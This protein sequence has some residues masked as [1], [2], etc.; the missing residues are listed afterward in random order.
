MNEVRAMPAAMML[1]GLCIT[2]ARAEETC[3]GTYGFD[4]E[5]YTLGKVKANVKRSYFQGD[6]GVPSK[7][8]VV[9]GDAVMVTNRKPDAVCAVYVSRKGD[10]TSGWLNLVDIDMLAVP[11]MKPRAW[12]GKWT[13]G[14]RANLEISAA[15]K[16][17]LSV[18]GEALWGGS[19]ADIENGNVNTGGVDGDAPVENGVLSFAV[20]MDGT[21]KTFAEAG[22]YE[23]AIRLRPLGSSYLLAED[24]KN[25]GGHNVSFTGL[26]A[27][28]N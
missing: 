10:E 4:E 18:S 17:W 28:A 13:A 14:E 26:Y 23:C 9:R 22:E 15:K 12:I 21:S 25:C 24:N 16:G 11:D 2:G 7:S 5:G 20:N 27:R 3:S 1:L 6:D 19:T 8:Y